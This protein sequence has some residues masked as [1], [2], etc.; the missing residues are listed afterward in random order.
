MN[1]L[2]LTTDFARR[3][4]GYTG[5]SPAMLKAFEAMRQDGIREA[6]AAHFERKRAVDELKAS[7]AMFFVSIRPALCTDEAIADANR[8][9]FNHRNLSSWMKEVHRKRLKDAKQRL[10][11]ARYFRRFGKRLWV[12]EAA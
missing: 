1:A 8:V 9:I 3:A 12:R 11:I 7:P 10:V 4:G 2:D 5:S 6:R